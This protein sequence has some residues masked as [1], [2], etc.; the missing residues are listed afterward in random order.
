MS[1]FGE[2]GARLYRGDVSV[3]FVGRRKTWYLVSLAIV[4]VAIATLLLRGLNYGIEFRGGV[5]F[6]AQIANPSANVEKL[7]DAVV[8]TGI[9]A[10]S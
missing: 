9:E 6:N 8:E 3:D 2:L 1:K 5:E 4:V 10:A 7:T